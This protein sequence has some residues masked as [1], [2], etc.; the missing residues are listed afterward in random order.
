MILL[1]NIFLQATGST[2]LCSAT[3]VEEARWLKQH[4]VDAIMAQ[5]AEAGGH[6]GTFLAEDFREAAHS[7]VGTLTL[8]AEVKL[9]IKIN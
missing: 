9:Y 3:T 6:R 5:G 1:F 4:G 2:V 8:V 7:Q